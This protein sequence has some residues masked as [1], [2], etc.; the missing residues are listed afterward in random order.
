MRFGF[1]ILLNYNGKATSQI[2]KLNACGDPTFKLGRKQYFVV[3]SFAPGWGLR[4]S[5][6]LHFREGPSLFPG[7]SPAVRYSS[8][9]LG[10]GWLVLGSLPRGSDEAPHLLRHH[11]PASQGVAGQSLS[12]LWLRDWHFNPALPL[13]QEVGFSVCSHPVH[14]PLRQIFSSIRRT[15]VLAAQ[16]HSSRLFIPREKGSGGGCVPFLQC[17]LPPAPGLCHEGP[18]LRTLASLF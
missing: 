12:P 4:H 8:F 13:G 3:F 7:H 16:T 14:V 10:I 17:L 18:F 9:F 5:L 11:V 15:T 2:C 1:L 6:A